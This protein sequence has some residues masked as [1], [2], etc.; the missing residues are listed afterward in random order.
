MPTLN[1]SLDEGCE[2]TELLRPWATETFHDFATVLPTANRVYV[3][4]RKQFAKYNRLIRQL[5]DSNIRVVYSNPFEGSETLHYIIRKLRF[6]DLL[7]SKK[8]LLISGGDIRVDCDYLRH[9]HFI[10]KVHH[11]PENLEVIQHSDQIY[12]KINKPYKFLFLNGR[13]RPHRKW[14]VEQLDY[15]GLLDQALWTWLDPNFIDD[16]SLCLE[17]HGID[18]MNRPRSIKLLPSKYEVQRYQN[19][20]D[21]QF[22]D[23]KYAMPTLFNEE[24]GAIYLNLDTYVDTY[25]SIVTETVHDKPFSFRTEKIWKPIA[26]GHPWVCVANAGFNRD[27]RNMGFRTFHGIIDESFDNIEDNHAR[28]QGVINV[29]IDICKSPREFLEA[30][31]DICKYNQDHMIHLREQINKDFPDK[32]F[33]LLNNNQWMI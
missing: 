3:F 1:L 2:T 27:L 4:G 22:S 20:V 25:F 30:A 28:L 18:L 7:L 24:W 29:I 13:A 10:S 31:R 8:I 21:M 9:D 33:K 14:M 5:V 32:F 6:E 26:I 17:Q 12:T 11:F 15:L 16:E 19:R 23:Q